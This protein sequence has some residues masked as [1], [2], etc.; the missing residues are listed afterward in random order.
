MMRDAF[1]LYTALEGEDVN[2]VHAFAIAIKNS[3]P[4]EE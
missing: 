4:T 1:N 3:L 2:V